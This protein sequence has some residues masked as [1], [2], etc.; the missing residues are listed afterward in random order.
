MWQRNNVSKCIFHCWYIRRPCQ[1]SALCVT[2]GSCA[3][4]VQGCIWVDKQCPLQIEISICVWKMF[5]SELQGGMML[6]FSPLNLINTQ[7][8]WFVTQSL[9]SLFL[10]PSLFL[11]TSLQLSLSVVTWVKNREQMKETTSSPQ[12]EWTASSGGG[13]S[14]IEEKLSSFCSVFQRC[15]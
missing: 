2:L 13:P 10:L 4:A 8:F 12:W 15:S 3:C 6:F 9:R 7:K 14:V 11:S 5:E 1:I